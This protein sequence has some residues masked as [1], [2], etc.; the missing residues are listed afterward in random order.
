MG[1]GKGTRV[2]SVVF[3]MFCSFMDY[4]LETDTAKC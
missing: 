3:L 2:A 4:F 1:S